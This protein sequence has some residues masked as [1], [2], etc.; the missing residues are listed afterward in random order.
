MRQPRSV[1][2]AEP[3]IRDAFH[4]FVNGAQ[5]TTS[6]WKAKP[7]KGLLSYRMNYFLNRVLISVVLVR[8]YLVGLP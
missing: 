7:D 6:H 3:E 8:T 5:K 2:Q 4:D 1:L